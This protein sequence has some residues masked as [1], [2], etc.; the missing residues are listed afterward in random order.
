MIADLPAVSDEWDQM[1]D[2]ERASWSL[3]WDQQMYTNLGMLDDYCRSQEMTVE[4]QQQYRA[5]L[6]ELKI[7]LPILD[8]LQL[9]RPTVPLD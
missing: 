1:D 9:C 4:Q 2:M 6:R 3:D 5:L 7:A 8:R